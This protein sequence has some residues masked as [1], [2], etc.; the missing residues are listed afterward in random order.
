MERMQLFLNIL[1][2]PEKEIKHFVHIAGTSGKGSVG[3]FMQSILHT[4]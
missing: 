3:T 2:N 1:G 4:H